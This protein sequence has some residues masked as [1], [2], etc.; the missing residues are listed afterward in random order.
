MKKEELLKLI[1]DDFCVV[2][3][4][5]GSKFERLVDITNGFFRGDGRGSIYHGNGSYY[6]L[7]H[8]QTYCSRNKWGKVYTLEEFETLL[9][10]TSRVQTLEIF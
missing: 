5:D 3:N 9:S 7:R 8:N 6:G 1:G 4:E 2:I 10:S